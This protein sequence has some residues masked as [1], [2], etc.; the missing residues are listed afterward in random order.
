MNRIPPHFSEWLHQVS[1]S[2]CIW[3]WL[4]CQKLLQP[5]HCSNNWNGIWRGEPLEEGNIQWKAITSVFWTVYYHQF[6]QGILHCN[7]ICMDRQEVLL[8]WK[9]WP[10]LGYFTPCLQSYNDQRRTILRAFLL[11]IGESMPVWCPKTS[12]LGSIPNISYEPR[13]SVPLDTMFKNGVECVGL[14]IYF[15]GPEI[16]IEKYSFGEQ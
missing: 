10:T 14:S 4:V 12:K 13:K 15:Q 7:W 9:T 6:L 3:S 8:S 5:P 2:R 16:Q 11:I 1:L